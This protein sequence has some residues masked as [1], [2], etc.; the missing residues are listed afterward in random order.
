MVHRFLKNVH[1]AQYFALAFVRSKRARLEALTKLWDRLER[2]YIRSI[3][4]RK[5]SQHV[6]GG[7]VS[8]DVIEILDLDPRLK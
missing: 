6:S 3:L 4:T 2:S 7:M 5:K 1:R 8:N